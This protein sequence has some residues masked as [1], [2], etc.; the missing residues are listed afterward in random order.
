MNNFKIM[1]NTNLKIV[2]RSFIKQKLIAGLSILALTLGIASFIFIFIYIRYE[3]SYD[4]FWKNSERIYR[5]PLEKILKN[6]NKTNTATNYWGLSR[7]LKSEI[8]GIEASSSLMEDVVT[9]HSLNNYISNAKLYYTDS[10]FFSVFNL[11]L[12]AGDNKNPFPSI[13]S[14]VISESAALKLFG[15]RS[16]LSKHFKL[17]EGWEFVVDGIYKDIQANSHLKIDILI[18]RKSL[19]YYLKNFNAATLELNTEHVKEAVEPSATKRGFW[20]NPQAYTYIRIAKNVN[21]LSI[22]AYFPRIY[23]KYTPHLIESGQKSKFYLQ[24]VESIHFNSHLDHE[25]SVNSNHN[26]VIALRIIAFLIL[27]ISWI[28]FVNFQIVQTAEKAKEIGIKKV[29]GV[30]S[31]ALTWQVIIQSAISNCI[32][33]VLAF[34]LFVALR[35]PLYHYLDIDYHLLHISNYIWIFIILFPLGAVLTGLYPAYV[36]ISRSAPALLKRSILNNDG[37]NLRKSLI[38]FQFASSIG[39]LIATVFIMKQVWYMKTK[40]IGLNLSKTVCSYT[41]MCNIKRP[42]AQEKL[43]RFLDEVKKLPGVSGATLSS[44]IPGREA[45]YHSN[46]IFS[47]GKP[48]M[49]GDNFGILTIDHHFQEVYKPTLMAGRF[50]TEEDISGGNQVIISYESLK[51]FGFQSP[52]SALGKFIQ[53]SLSDYFHIPDTTFQVCGVIEDIHLLSLR[54]NLEPLLLLKNYRW[55]YEVGY[56]SI[57]MSV[58]KGNSTLKAIH[59]KWLQFYPDNPFDFNFSEEIY[60]LQLAAD[61]KLAGIFGLYAAFSIL[62][63]AIGLFGLASNVAKKRT[64]EIGVRKVNGARAIQILLLLN[65]DFIKWVAIAFVIACPAAYFAM[66]QWLQNY[67]Y[68]T[69]LSWWVFVFAGV[70][71]ISIALITVSWQCWR[72]AT[73]NPVEALRYE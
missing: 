55:K 50:F 4:S 66:S 14:A 6:G 65:K 30:S 54:S 19:F 37:F 70:I 20:V 10:S 52:G 7:V 3:S 59:N 23:E 29:V 27:I 40:D 33:I 31:P 73:R 63:S 34:I 9:A 47:V 18:S 15:T 26:T 21:P 49:K 32:S 71:A 11:Y 25:M 46:T 22:E 2:L 51:R 72:V 8:P 16:A 38:I 69:A 39:L 48:E 64:K 13:H 58:N 42:G 53:V 17:N 67:A 35:K 60:G 56:I 44:G 41:P 24:P 68:H 28:I 5:I 45:T 61:Q 1:N 43:I 62:L 57:R 12:I 36:L